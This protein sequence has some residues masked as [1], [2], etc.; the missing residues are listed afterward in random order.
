M[1]LSNTKSKV[2]IA[3]EIENLIVP[4]SPE[5]FQQL[6]LNILSEGC[7]D[8]LIVW[9]G[10]NKK[11]ILLDGHNRFKICQ[12]HDIDYQIKILSFQDYTE[13]KFWMINNQLGRRNLNRD[14][15][16]YYRGLKYNNFKKP[17]GGFEKV[18]SKG[19]TQPSTSI[20]LAKE[21]NISQSTIKRDAKFA[22]GLSIVGQSNPSLMKR[23]LAGKSKVKKIDLQVLADAENPS[24][25]VIKNEA[26]LYNKAKW[27]RENTLAQ[28]E[29][30][31]NNNRE[32][33]VKKAQEIL[34]ARDPMFLKAEDRIVRLKGQ[35][36]SVV[37]SAIKEKDPT[38]LKELSGLIKKLA[39]VIAG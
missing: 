25:L 23:I 1:E 21:F 12:K 35:I 9:E 31:H 17:K 4:L 2:E 16:S 28:L 32:K 15:M 5:E 11:L 37:N 19:Q 20:R 39:Q 34:K 3:R 22:T 38:R 24:S 7:R 10:T 8:P 6:E 26:D 30:E 33:K 13:A 14:Q 27:I 36:L 18:R 29:K